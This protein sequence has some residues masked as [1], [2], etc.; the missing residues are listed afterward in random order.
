MKDVSKDEVRNALFQMH[1]DKAPGPD[2]MTPAFFQKHWNVVGNDVFEVVIDFF[3]E[4]TGFQELNRTNVV[5]IPK[6]KDPIKVTDM[7]PIYLCNV[8]SK[9]VTKVMANRLKEECIG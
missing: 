6:K 7:R 5:L 3:R 4:G 1:P 8:L 2:G 9:V